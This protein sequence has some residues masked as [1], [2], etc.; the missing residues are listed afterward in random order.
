MN[1]ESFRDYCLA[2]PG[3]TE[4]FPFDESTLVFKVGGKMFALTDLEEEFR[5]ALKC[6]PQYSIE[7]RERFSAITP[8]YH[9]SKIHWIDVNNATSFDE[10]L[11]MQLIDESYEL[12]FK[13]LTKK[14]RDV[15]RI[16][17]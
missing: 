16:N 9:M 17:G 15:I 1:I 12:V 7:L 4:E 11:L 2:K 6:D 10:K 14:M 5:V 13:G 8:A 3:V